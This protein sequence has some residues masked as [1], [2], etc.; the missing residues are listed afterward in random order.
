MITEIVSW[1]LPE[2]MSREDTVAKYRLS[3]PTWQ[4]NADLIHKAFLFDEGARRAGGVY[5]WKNVDAAK[6]AHGEAFRPSCG[7]SRSATILSRGLPKSEHSAISPLMRVWGRAPAVP[8][9]HLAKLF[10]F[11]LIGIAVIWAGLP[12]EAAPKKVSRPVV[13]RAAK[14]EGEL[15]P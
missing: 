7:V 14:F 1:H 3:V 10:F 12:K 15:G 2:G 4:A 11:V 5:L 8:A 6:Q 13:S 9:S